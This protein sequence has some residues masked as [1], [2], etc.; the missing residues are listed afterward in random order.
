MVP[1]GSANE[2]PGGPKR[3]NVRG[4][5]LYCAPRVTYGAPPPQPP[6]TRSLPTP[7]RHRPPPPPPGQR[8][9]PA[10][11]RNAR[12]PPL[13]PPP[14]APRPYVRGR[15]PLE[16]ARGP[17]VPVRAHPPCAP[18]PPLLARFLLAEPCAALPPHPQQAGSMSRLAAAHAG[19]CSPSLRVRRAREGVAGLHD[20]GSL[21]RQARRD[22]RPRA[23]I[24]CAARE[25]RPLGC[26]A[27]ARPE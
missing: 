24:G 23:L 9:E 22:G 7:L 1:R 10:A 12:R 21:A 26:G 14:P 11:V 27:A 17:R 18:F 15:G 20:P 25:P 2:M 13:A 6:S 4:K 5:R 19:S 3:P 16:A 8:P